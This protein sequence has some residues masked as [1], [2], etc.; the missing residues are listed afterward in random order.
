M[1]IK[2]TKGISIR[3]TLLLLGLVPMLITGI[4]SVTLSLVNL[5][6]EIKNGEYQA[7]YVAAENVNQYFAYDIINNG[8]V[9]YDEYS[10]HEF[11]ESLKDENIVLTLYKGD[12]SF[13]SSVRG[14]DGKYN[15]GARVDASIYSKLKAG[16]KYQADNVDL[17][18]IDYFVYYEPIFD[19]EGAFWGIA[20]AG[21]PVSQV[22][23]AITASFLNIGAV[24]IIILIIFI[25]LI[26][27][28]A[29]RIFK[30]MKA[31]TEALAVLSTGNLKPVTPT[32]SIVREINQITEATSGL[33][34]QLQIAV[35][36][37]KDTANNLS[38]VSASVDELSENSASG[39]DLIA[40][41]VGEMA[42]AAM[43][44]AETVQNANESII[45][46]GESISDI[47]E[48]AENSSEASVAMKEVSGKTVN[49]MKQVSE[50][51]ET[52]VGSIE[53]IDRLTRECAEAVGQ[54]KTAAEMI[55]SIASQT[56]LLALNASI[57]AAR[58]GESGKGFAVVADNIKDLA[59]QSSDS[60]SRIDEYVNDIVIKV[61]KCVSASKSA[62]EVIRRQAELVREASGSMIELNKN[63]DLVSENVNQ[64]S[65]N[66]EMLNGAKNSVLHN[67]SDLSAI[68]EENAASSEQVAN[69]VGEVVV[70]VSST[71]D[72]SKRMKNLASELEDKMEFFT[73]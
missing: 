68:S 48:K 28:V 29:G 51:N 34:N 65:K 35:G 2:K 16:E 22:D 53:Q 47:A 19:G 13:L 46:M 20:F 30:S 50:A 21:T 37:A 9:D 71:K 24:N 40:R 63:V 57:E 7:L 64:I 49:I 43:S 4:V 38:S 54:I 67:I 14:A 58:A 55:S 39:T 15:E 27:I 72:E 8:D 1:E 17:N 11:M 10:D 25:I 31:A 26:C 73:I 18:G 56:N 59:G 12:V 41:V 6:K 3:L 33:Q 62:E 61:E 45:N 70:S 23:D 60:A 5:Q 42:T 36:G 44:M 66:A 32:E 69:S 52:S